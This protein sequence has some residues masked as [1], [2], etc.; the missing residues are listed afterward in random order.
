MKKTIGIILL[1]VVVAIVA[2]G[3]VYL[4]TRDS[5]KTDVVVNVENIKNI[6]QLATVEY[7]ISTYLFREK[8]KKIYEWL[9]AKFFVF[10]KGKVKG[11]VDLDQAVIEVSPDPKNRMVKIT[12]KKGAVL[13]SDPEIA[14][15]DIKIMTCADP[16]IFH[17]ISDADRNKAMR[18][19]I[20]LLKKTAIDDGI[21]DKA[22]TE[23]KL[24]LTTFLQSLGYASQIEFE[25]KS[26][27]LAD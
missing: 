19:V 15:D 5:G 11:S 20:A 17:K 25:D 14:Q 2:G 24:V 6:A 27:K 10:V 7:H 9:S 1:V 12:F 22:A 23:A 13:V 8:G 16:N 4:L 3:F 26:L 18:D 21:M